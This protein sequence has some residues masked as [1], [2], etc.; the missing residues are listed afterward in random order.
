MDI[1][2]RKKIEIKRKKMIQNKLTIKAFYQGKEIKIIPLKNIGHFFDGL[3]VL[4]SKWQVKPFLKLW[5][6]EN[7][8]V[9][10]NAALIILIGLLYKNMCTKKGFEVN[11]KRFKNEMLLKN[12]NPKVFLLEADYLNFNDLADSFSGEPDEKA[13]MIAADHLY[14]NAFKKLKKFDLIEKSSHHGYIRLTDQYSDY[15][16]KLGNYLFDTEYARNCIKRNTHYFG[17]SSSYDHS[18][19]LEERQLIN[20][21]KDKLH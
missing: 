11:A 6:D 16:Q 15:C 3:H 18:I 10:N 21:D 17:S 8:D 1:L 19:A 20:I 7:G 4:S 9:T 12:K 5:N 2:G 13:V 14:E